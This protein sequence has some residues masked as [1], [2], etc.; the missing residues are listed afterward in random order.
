MI[1]V[2]RIT[3]MTLPL[4]LSSRSMDVFFF[5]FPLLFIAAVVIF[6]LITSSSANRRRHMTWPHERPC[7]NCQTSNPPHA[8]FCRRCGRRLD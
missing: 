3:D 1:P 2:S 8:G 4:L 5:P 7:R 6:I